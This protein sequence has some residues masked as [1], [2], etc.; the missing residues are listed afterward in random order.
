MCTAIQG[1]KQSNPLSLSEPS[2]WPL[3][4]NRWCHVREVFFPLFCSHQLSIFVRL[5]TFLFYFIIFFFLS[6][7]PPFQFIHPFI[8]PLL[9]CSSSHY[10]FCLSHFLF[11]YRSRPQHLLFF[12][13]Q[14]FQ[15]SPL[16]PPSTVEN[17]K[18]Q[19]PQTTASCRTIY[20]SHLTNSSATKKKHPYIPPLFTSFGQQCTKATQYRNGSTF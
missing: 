20:L 10:L 11:L 9:V 17:N 12:F 4:K 14:A 3:R 16:L 1:S 2:L 15:T 18:Q 7:T 5:S 6:Y 8:P 19:Q 13:L